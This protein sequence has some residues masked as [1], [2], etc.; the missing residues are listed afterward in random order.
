[1][2]NSSGGGAAQSLS[3]TSWAEYC[4]RH[5]RA[6][7]SDF[8]RSCAHYIAK[9]KCDTVSHRDFMRKF[10]EIFS[11]HFDS[12]YTRRRTQNKVRIQ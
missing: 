6:A 1:M 3:S 7:A 2:N 4:E 10:I 9:N 8:A 12:E 11:D 5:A